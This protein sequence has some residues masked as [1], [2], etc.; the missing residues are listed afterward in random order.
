MK[1]YAGFKFLKL[2]PASLLHFVPQL[3]S[4]FWSE[5]PWRLSAATL[6]GGRAQL[7]SSTCCHSVI[8]GGSLAKPREHLAS[9]RKPLLPG[10]TKHATYLHCS[11]VGQIFP[12][13]PRGNRNQ[14]S[15]SPSQS[16]LSPQSSS[17]KYLKATE[18]GVPFDVYIGWLLFLFTSFFNNQSSR[19]CGELT[20]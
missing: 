18:V 6:S 2:P 1:S 10:D 9:L 14:P 12:M 17:G 3:P 13:S 7:S 16:L 11:L 19:K 4:V 20:A 15:P 8:A 5:A